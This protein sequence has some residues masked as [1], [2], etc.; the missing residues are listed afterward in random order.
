MEKLF[1]IVIFT[2]FKNFQFSQVCKASKKT[3]VQNISETEVS[4]L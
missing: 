3:Y 1:Q 2:L 4:R